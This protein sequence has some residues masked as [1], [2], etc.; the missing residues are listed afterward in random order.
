M[1]LRKLLWAFIALALPVAA[2]A[3]DDED[4]NLTDVW[5]FV[6]KADMVEE[7][8]AGATKYMKWRQKQD[9]SRRYVAF[10]P[11]VG[12][13]LKPIMYRACCFTWA[14]QD[15]YTAE[16]VEKGYGEKFN[17][18]IAPYVDH[19]H[20]YIEHIDRDNS[21][22]TDDD[23]GPY[24]GV[25]SWSIGAGYQPEAYAARVRMSELAKDGWASDSNQ[26]LW[27]TRTGGGRV[28]AVVSPFSNWADMAPPEVSF[29]NFLID[30]IGEDDTD[31]LFEDFSSGKKKSDYTVWKMDDELSWPDDDE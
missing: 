18:M 23:K 28:L 30:K 5:I 8:R 6:P 2:L 22:W 25:T 24:F 4:A 19:T 7:F 21:H 10:V 12:H 27:V 15:T 3:Q 17:E 1:K 29:R 9:D 11:V 20:R 26:W 31:A 13:N 14:D 16:V